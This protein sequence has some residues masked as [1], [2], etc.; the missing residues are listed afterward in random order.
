MQAYMHLR[1]ADPTNFPPIPCSVFL[2]HSPTN[3]GINPTLFAT[4]RDWDSTVSSSGMVVKNAGKS[5]SRAIRPP[6]ATQMDGIH[7]VADGPRCCDLS[8]VLITLPAVLLVDPEIARGV[9]G[10][11][12]AR[13]RPEMSDHG[14]TGLVRRTQRT[15]PQWPAVPD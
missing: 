1:F 8:R 6:L 9:G 14:P 3:P 12:S 13:H 7:S 10:G 15:C 5:P 2:S 11:R 4:I